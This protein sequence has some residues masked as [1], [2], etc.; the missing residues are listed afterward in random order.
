[1]RKKS[2]DIPRE[3]EM[4]VL[5][6]AVLFA[7][8]TQVNYWNHSEPTSKWEREMDQAQRSLNGAVKRYQTANALLERGKTIT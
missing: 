8:C 7:A 4:K 3:S 5:R 6:L 1:M 2:A